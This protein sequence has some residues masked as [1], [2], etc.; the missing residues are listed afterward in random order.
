MFSKEI[1]S[2]KC[3]REVVNIIMRINNSKCFAKRYSKKFHKVHQKTPVPEPPFKLLLAQPHPN[4]HNF[5][6]IFF[7]ILHNL[8]NSDTKYYHKRS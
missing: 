5:F 6:F 4:L 2:K 3:L 1:L 8:P 7:L